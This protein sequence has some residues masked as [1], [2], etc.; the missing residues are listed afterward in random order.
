MTM[1]DAPDLAPAP[2]VGS[3]ADSYV[4]DI[5]AAIAEAGSETVEDAAES[6]ADDLRDA[7][8]GDAATADGEAAWR[9]ELNDYVAPHRDALN[10]LGKGK[11]EAIRRL[12]K[13]EQVLRQDPV[14]GLRW[15]AEA[16]GVV[17]RESSAGAV[18][19]Y[20][21]PVASGHD[22]RIVQDLE[23]FA[24]AK[25]ADGQPLRPHFEAVRVQMGGLLLAA[26]SA[27]REMSLDD[28][29]QAATWGNPA[30]REQMT[31]AQQEAAAKA[32]SEAQR[33]AIAKA[34][35][36][37]TP[38]TSSVPVPAEDEDDGSSDYATV[39]RA[40]FARRRAS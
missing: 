1:P 40:E 12:F 11:K 14:G 22:P 21:A 31:K 15:L 35:A 7:L 32:T 30:L 13:A 8:R 38:R 25:G 4:G 3:D 33:Q 27:G 37:R 10:A 18:Q 34:K 29:Y 17:P 9:K 24:S 19:Q 28:A 26:A 36:A 2:D 23:T 16:Y 39:L 20:Q 5:E 6:Y